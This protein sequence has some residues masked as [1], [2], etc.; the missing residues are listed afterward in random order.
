M[1]SIL[2]F[3]LAICVIVSC[4]PR[5]VCQQKTNDKAQ[6]RS[7]KIK[8]KVFDI[9]LNERVTVRLAN[10]SKVYGAIKNIEE[11][12]FFVAEVDRV[13]LAEINF[14]DVVKVYEG[15]CE[16]NLLTGNRKCPSPRTRKIVSIAAFG[17]L[18]ALVIIA[19]ASLK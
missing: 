1:K 14:N 10:N 18:F 3:V 13:N 9:G 6:Q 15:Y 12:R 4:T 19:A 16:T 5:A 2:C 8:R 17:G 7:E 11:D